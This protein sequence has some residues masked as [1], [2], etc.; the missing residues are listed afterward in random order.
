MLACALAP[1]LGASIPSQL[2][3]ADGT[4]LYCGRNGATPHFSWRSSVAVVAT[5][6][7]QDSVV[8][9]S[10]SRT[11]A[12]NEIVADT[13]PAILERYVRSEPLPVVGGSNTTYYWRVRHGGSTVWS[14]VG[15]FTIK[16]PPTTT[17]PATLVD[18]CSE[19]AAFRAAVSTAFVG[20]KGPL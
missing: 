14:E 8:H 9:I 10:R 17:V 15:S 3:P 19:I 20:G 2:E 6:G 12:P 7:A 11:F 5:D 16:V 1:V 18:W 4:V 13:V